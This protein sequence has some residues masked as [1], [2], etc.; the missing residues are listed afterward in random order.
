MEKYLKIMNMDFTELAS[1]NQNMLKSDLEILSDEQFESLC[2]HMKISKYRL[3]EENWD[4]III[5]KTI[6]KKSN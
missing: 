3:N 5:D 6:F 1:L 2:E 4:T